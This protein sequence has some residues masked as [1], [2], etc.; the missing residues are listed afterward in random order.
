MFLD[1]RRLTSLTI[2]L[3]FFFF[4]EILLVST[5]IHVNSKSDPAETACPL[6]QFAAAAAKFLFVHKVITPK[7]LIVVAVLPVAEFFIVPWGFIRPSPI[8]GPPVV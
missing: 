2:V 3:S 5:H 7:S 1:K 6:C 4:F 8:R